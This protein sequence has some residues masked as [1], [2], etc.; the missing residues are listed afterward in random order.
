LPLP[1]S[2][3]SSFSSL[4]SFD[5]CRRQVFMP[6]YCDRF[7]RQ[8]S[9]SSFLHNIFTLPLGHFHISSFPHRHAFIIYAF[10][11]HTKNVA[12]Y[13]PSF[14]HN[15]SHISFSYILFNAT[16]IAIPCWYIF[17]FIV[18]LRMPS[19]ARRH[20]CHVYIISSVPVRVAGWV[21]ASHDRDI[22]YMP[23]I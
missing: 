10:L 1:F 2:L 17:S 18:L 19:P 7:I 13:R 12:T 23:F 11:P 9:Y 16:L 5:G 21:T 20:Y 3:F 22:H 8:T 15:K 6:D 14:P 4:P